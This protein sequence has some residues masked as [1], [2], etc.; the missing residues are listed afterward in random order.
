MITAALLNFLLNKYVIGSIAGIIA[1]IYAYQKGSSAAEK[2]NEEARL[3]ARAKLQS[4]IRAA[5][6]KNAFLE[7]KGDK[8]NADISNAKSI[9][10]LLGLWDSHSA[11][12]DT[13]S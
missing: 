13:D 12:K 2:A 6:A 8:I 3:L 7:K 5:E 11:G 1:L 9:D 4:K 10:Q